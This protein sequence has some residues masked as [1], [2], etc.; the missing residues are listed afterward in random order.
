MDDK[1]MNRA[2]RSRL[3][4]VRVKAGFVPVVRLITVGLEIA[5]SEVEG[6][7]TGAHLTV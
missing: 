6:A 5:M 2:F 4:Q 7:A 3:S 1:V